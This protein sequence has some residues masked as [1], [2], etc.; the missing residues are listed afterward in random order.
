MS[1]YLGLI[2]SQQKSLRNQ[3]AEAALPLRVVPPQ[4]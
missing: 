3:T 2:M 4:A 1:H